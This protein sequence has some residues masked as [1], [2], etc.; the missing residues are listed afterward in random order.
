MII[1]PDGLVPDDQDILGLGAPIDVT[2]IELINLVGLVNEDDSLTVELGNGDNNARIARG[3]DVAGTGADL[4]T[5]DSLPDIGFRGLDDFALVGQAGNDVAT[6]VTWFLTGAT[7]TNYSFDGGATDALII[8]GS[9]GAGSVGNDRMV[10]TNPAGGP[11]AVQDTNGANVIVT[12]TNPMQG[13]LQINTLGGDDRVLVNADAAASDVIGVPIT[14]DGGSG[15]D[16]LTVLGAPVTAVNEVIYSP[17]QAVTDGRLLYQDANDGTLMTID[18]TNLEPVLESLLATDFTVNGTAEENDITYEESTLPSLGAPFGRV[19][20]DGFESIDFGNKTNLLLNGDNGNDTILIDNGDLPDGL[21]RVTVNGDNGNDEITVLAL[22]DASATAF[23]SATLNGHDGDDVIDASN[24]LVNTPLFITGFRGDDTLIGGRGNDTI[25]GNE[26]DDLM[27]GGDPAIT[28]D[29]GDNLYNGG[30]GYDT[31][32]ILGTS[33]ADTI[34][35]NQLTAGTLSSIVNGDTANET[36][37]DTEAARIDGELST[38]VIRLEINDGLFANAANPATTVLAYRVIGGA[39]T[40]NDRLHVIDDG[41]GD[42]I[43]H[44][45][46]RTTDTGTIRIAPAHPNGPAPRS[47]TNRSSE[48]M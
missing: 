12:A 45:Q 29:I 37:V 35:V 33:A 5:S 13:R 24:L 44:R 31:I 10:V 27:I 4:V 2:G 26:G 25:R 6:F 16:F 14:F 34:D 7:N 32:G 3:S 17:G 15:S 38:D 40:T 22:P 8:E 23:V 46:S 21:Q 28:P 11:V 30:D 19:T 20:V 41:L 47:P 39:N 9:D 43:I 42:T 36:F 48:S 1:R 18:F